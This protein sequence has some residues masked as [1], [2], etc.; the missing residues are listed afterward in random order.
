MTDTCR[1]VAHQCI[2][3][4]H[5][6]VLQRVLG[7]LGHWGDELMCGKC[8]GGEKQEVSDKYNI[9]FQRVS[10]TAAQAWDKHNIS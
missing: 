9:P 6:A 10:S 3:S 2:H 8:F 1:S 7:K 4:K 5:T